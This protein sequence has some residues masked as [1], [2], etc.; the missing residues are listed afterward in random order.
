MPDQIVTDT[1]ASLRAAAD[2]I[3]ANPQLPLPYITSHSDGITS[4]HWYLMLP[5]HDMSPTD[6]GAAALTIFD[7]VGGH[8][9]EKSGLDAEDQ[10]MTVWEQDRGSLHFH[11]AVRRE[12]AEVCS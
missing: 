10:P 12:V 7:A 5:Q 9:D 4:L 8:W 6:Q 1:A 3:Q 11:V 2:F